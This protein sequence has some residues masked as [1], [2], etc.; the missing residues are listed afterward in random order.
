MIA[1]R[2]ENVS[3]TLGGRRVLRDVS[4]SLPHP[5]ALVIMGPN[6]AGKTTLLRAI[7]GMVKRDGG[8]LEVFGADPEKEQEKVRGIASYLPQVSSV[9]QEVPVT[10]REIVMSPHLLSGEDP[11]LAERAMR[12]AG[13]EDLADKPFSE[14]SGGQKQRALIARALAKRSRLL[15]L[16]EPLSMVDVSAR[17][18]IVELLFEISRKEGITL[19]MVS[20]DVSH[21][22]KHDPLMLLLNGTVIAF[23]RA[24]EVLTDEALSKVYGLARLRERS[25]FVGEEHGAR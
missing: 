3:V 22:L 18:Q 10:V 20:H 15:I 1:V 6:G 4:F 5:S 19:I 14:L 25:F 17:E 12:I 8:L 7:L 11:S 9:N 23:G 2:A 24:E 21:C 13:I 16:D